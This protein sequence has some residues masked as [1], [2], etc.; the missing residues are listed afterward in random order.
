M[1][2]AFLITFYAY[3]KVMGSGGRVR[4]PPAPPAPLPPPPPPRGWT[5]TTSNGEERYQ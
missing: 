2:V 3:L 1:L 4:D 5:Q